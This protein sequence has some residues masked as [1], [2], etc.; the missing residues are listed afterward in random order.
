VAP[1]DRVGFDQER[2]RLFLVLHQAAVMSP[3]LAGQTPE[4]STRW[5]P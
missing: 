4:S 2:E 1:S 3:A 5:L